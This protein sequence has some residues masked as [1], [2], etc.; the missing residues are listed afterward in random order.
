LGVRP[1]AYPITW[2]LT[3]SKSGGDIG[4]YLISNMKPA[5]SSALA[6]HFA[7]KHPLLSI[8]FDS[9]TYHD[10]ME[11]NDLAM[12]VTRS[13]GIVIQPQQ[14]HESVVFSN[15]FKTQG[16]R[17]QLSDSLLSKAKLIA[18]GNSVPFSTQTLAAMGYWIRKNKEKFGT[19]SS[20]SIEGVL[21]TFVQHAWKT[22]S[23]NSPEKCHP[24]TEKEFFE[25]IFA[26]GNPVA[27]KDFKS[28]ALLTSLT[29]DDALESTTEGFVTTYGKCIANRADFLNRWDEIRAEWNRYTLLNTLG[30][31]M[32]STIAEFAGVQGNSISYTFTDDGETAHIDV[33]DDDSEGNGSCELAMKYFHLPF[34]VRETALKFKDDH[35]PSRSVADLLEQRLQLCP[36]HIVQNCAIANVKVDGLESYH[37]EQD[38]LRARFD[39]FWNQHDVTTLRQASLHARRRFAIEDPGDRGEQLK[40]ELAL[41]VCYDGCPSCSGDGMMNQM[42]PHLVSF[43]TNRGL[44]DEI[45]GAFFSLNGYKRMLIDYEDI[46]DSLGEK[47]DNLSP[48]IVHHTEVGQDFTIE[49][50][51]H[52]GSGVGFDLERNFIP[53]PELAVDIVVRT[54][55]LV[56]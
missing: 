55:E 24:S 51:H 30:V 15:K 10:E 46:Y 25:L 12:G 23:P 18:G 3:D 14:N 35:L 32:S 27:K 29:D 13:N 21:D 2:K 42:P 1:K 53:H 41:T 38:D 44:L 22:S 7:Q 56:G 45:I 33:F 31:L 9:V 49:F 54:Q 26:N 47:I 6:Q 19:E 16:I 39:V 17:F 8:L 4:T 43:S 5:H 37:S 34:E 48:L 11:I 28:R 40:L 50:R 20:F 52:L 36:E